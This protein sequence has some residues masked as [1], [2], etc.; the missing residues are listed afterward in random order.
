M[1][2]FLLNKI[3]N[4]K[5][6]NMAIIT[7]VLKVDEEGHLR[8]MDTEGH[9][10]EDNITTVVR[11]SDTVFWILDENSGISEITNIGAK[12]GSKNL[13]AEGPK[14]LSGSEWKGVIGSETKGSE[15]YFIEY[16]LEDGKRTTDDPR[17]IIDPH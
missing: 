10:S 6:K 4:L 7:I 14:P 12:P 15:S 13:F 17:I 11:S 5:F 16:I 1:H 3:S 9:S 8:L 2:L